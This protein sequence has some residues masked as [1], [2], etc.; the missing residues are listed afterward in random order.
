MIIVTGQT[1]TGKTKLA[2]ELA[3]KHNLLTLTPVKSIN[4]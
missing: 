2:Q 1:A 3:K 4:I